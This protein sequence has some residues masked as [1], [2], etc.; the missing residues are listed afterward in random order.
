MV[1]VSLEAA[2][3]FADCTKAGIVAAVILAAD[4]KPFKFLFRAIPT[5]CKTAALSALMADSSSSWYA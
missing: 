1:S 4:P 5:T 3:L 2:E